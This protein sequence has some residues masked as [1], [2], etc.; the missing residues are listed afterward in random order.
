[1]MLS[2]V[3]YLSIAKFTCILGVWRNSEYSKEGSASN[4]SVGTAAQIT[5]EIARY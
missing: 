1:M 5:N 3:F 4:D 2:M